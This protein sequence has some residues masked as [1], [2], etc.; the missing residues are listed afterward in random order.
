MSQIHGE[1]AAHPHVVAKLLGR[2]SQISEDAMIKLVGRTLHL[3][4]YAALAFA[5]TWQQCEVHGQGRGHKSAPLT[6]A[7]LD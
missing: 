1:Q 4:L 6:T 3:T 7:Q 2:R 5:L